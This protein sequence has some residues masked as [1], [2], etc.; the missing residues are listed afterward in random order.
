MYY[1]LFFSVFP[2]LLSN[3]GLPFCSAD[4]IP[5]QSASQP[6][7][8]LY[9][10]PPTQCRPHSVRFRSTGLLEKKKRMELATEYL[11]VYEVE[12]LHVVGGCDYYDSDP[13]VPAAYSCAPYFRGDNP[14][15]LLTKLEG[16]QSLR[17][18]FLCGVCRPAWELSSQC[19]DIKKGQWLWPPRLLS[20]S[21]FTEI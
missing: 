2:H 17:W 3:V 13:T 6:A 14:L 18:L 10:V 8:D 1:N 4:Y 5:S 21:C 16:T 15:E 19:R 20:L 12:S 7:L 11:T 9:L